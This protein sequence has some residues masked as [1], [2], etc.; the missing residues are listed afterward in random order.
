MIRGKLI[1]YLLNEC[2]IYAALSFFSALV[3][4][5]Q[6]KSFIFFM[7]LLCAFQIPMATR[8]RLRSH[9]WMQTS[10]VLYVKVHLR[11]DLYLVRFMASALNCW[12]SYLEN[13]LDNLGVVRPY[14]RP[15]NLQRLTGWGLTE[16]R[17]KHSCLKSHI[18]YSLTPSPPTNQNISPLTGGTT[19]GGKLILKSS[20][21]PSS[22]KLTF[23]WVEPGSV[24][25]R[26]RQGARQT[27]EWRNS[28]HCAHKE[29]LTCMF[30]CL[31]QHL[32]VHTPNTKCVR[33]IIKY[34]Q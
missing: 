4:Q 15:D 5:K 1:L 12:R 9:G 17:C 3:S 27:L 14:K 16:R 28:L 19:T 23:W 10:P 29:L 26:P 8:R 7:T 20:P 24:W 21:L 30:W 11:R 32:K 34:I 31:C 18:P 22:P 25:I 2:S 33:S 13:T 6:S